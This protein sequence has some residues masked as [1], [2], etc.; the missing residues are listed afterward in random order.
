[1]KRMVG[2]VHLQ[3]HH[4]LRQRCL[5]PDRRRRAERQRARRAAA[6]VPPASGWLPRPAG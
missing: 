3:R 4:P 5:L 1:V 6:V 2:K